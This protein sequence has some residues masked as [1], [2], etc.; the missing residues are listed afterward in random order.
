MGYNQ[1][2]I[3]AF[4]KLCDSSCLYFGKCQNCRTRGFARIC[5]DKLFCC[6]KFYCTYAHYSVNTFSTKICQHHPVN[7]SGD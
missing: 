1:Q 3:M 7:V 5:G 6:K 2:K 4:G